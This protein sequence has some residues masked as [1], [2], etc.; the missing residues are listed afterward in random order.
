M[1]YSGVGLALC[2]A[3]LVHKSA[4]M[5]QKDVTASTIAREYSSFKKSRGRGDM[6]CMLPNYCAKVVSHI[7]L[8]MQV[9]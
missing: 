8:S 9:L 4:N 2:F 1:Q 3:W 6:Q 5:N 7:S